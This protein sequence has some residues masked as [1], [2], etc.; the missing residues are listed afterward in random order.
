MLLAFL[1]LRTEPWTGQVEPEPHIS[2]QMP[3]FPGPHVY[4]P[5]SLSSGP[6]ALLTLGLWLLPHPVKPPLPQLCSVLPLCSQVSIGVRGNGEMRPKA[7]EV[8][9]SAESPR[10]FR[11][12][13]FCWP[14]EP[15]YGLQ[16]F[17][18]GEVTSRPASLLLP[19][20]RPADV[21][22][23]H[24]CRAGKGVVWGRRETWICPHSQLKL[25]TLQARCAVGGGGPMGRKAGRQIG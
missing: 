9:P 4:S 5:G 17:V 24:A 22:K 10:G 3:A 12:E 11:P 1:L 25:S 20:T 21:H 2:L 18:E 13:G 16:N 15:G 6:T 8:R 19:S 14:A 23:H 7:G